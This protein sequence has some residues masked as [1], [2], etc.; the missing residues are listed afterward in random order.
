VASL[1]PLLNFCPLIYRS[2]K[3]AQRAMALS[4][5]LNPS[6]SR[7]APPCMYQNAITSF[8]TDRRCGDEPGAGYAERA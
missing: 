5:A 7:T 4:G 3:V 2:H 8:T 1:F 6:A